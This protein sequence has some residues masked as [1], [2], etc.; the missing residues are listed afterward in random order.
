MNYT[1]KQLQI[2]KF[3]RDYRRENQTSP[4]LEEI[5]R[6]LGVHRVTVHQHVAALV[7]TGRLD[8][9]RCQLAK[10][11]ELNRLGVVEEAWEFNEWCHGVSGQPMG[12]P[13]QAWSAGIYVFAHHCVNTAT[14]PFLS[15]EVSEELTPSAK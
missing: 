14:V 9:A 11:A 2:M 5:G 1:P 13:H 15:A 3:I 12:Y 8:E 10:L 6:S 4:T 7:K